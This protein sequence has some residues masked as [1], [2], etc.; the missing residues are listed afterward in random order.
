MNPIVKWL[1]LIC[2]VAAP[3]FSQQP[4]T[5]TTTSLPNGALQSFYNQ[6]ISTANG[7]SPYNWSTPQGLP[8]GL[9]LGN[10]T[11]PTNTISGTPTQTG[12]FSFVINVFDGQRRSAS[13]IRSITV[14]PAANITTTGLANRQVTVPY[15]SHIT[16]SGGT[17]PD[18]WALSAGNVPGLSLSTSGQFSGT[19]PT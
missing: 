11:G 12:T 1:S 3:V 16:A 8:P 9:T 19:P 5:I 2:V 18:T 4:Y 13:N 14:Q 6:T 10:S 17:P 7:V 15:T